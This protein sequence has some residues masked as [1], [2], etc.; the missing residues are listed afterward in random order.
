MAPQPKKSKVIEVDEAAT[1]EMML[2]VELSDMQ[3][4]LDNML[5]DLDLNIARADKAE[6][7][8]E[9]AVAANKEFSK[10]IETLSTTQA[11]LIKTL[12][13][14]RESKRTLLLAMQV[15]QGQHSPLAVFVPLPT[16]NQE[17][18]DV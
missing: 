12:E 15:T 18:S 1:R 16:Q 8:L 4:K 11:A 14:E 10:K 6:R 17:V 2:E 9:H 7:S 3:R 13:L 5:K